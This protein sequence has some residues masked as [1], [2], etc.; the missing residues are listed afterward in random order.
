MVRRHAKEKPW[1]LHL[2]QPL[3]DVGAA[4][5]TCRHGSL[6]SAACGLTVLL[7]PRPALRPP[8]RAHCRT[9]Y[10]RRT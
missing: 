5:R 2:R 9:L 6:S 10:T 1:A 4:L 3:C 7:P 8:P